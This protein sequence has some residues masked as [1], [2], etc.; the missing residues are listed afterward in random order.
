MIQAALVTPQ[1]HRSRLDHR[2][3]AVLQLVGGGDQ[4]FEDRVG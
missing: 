3:R 4:G 1:G 2:E